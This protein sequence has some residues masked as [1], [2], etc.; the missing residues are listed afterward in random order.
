MPL[1]RQQRRAAARA[2]TSRHPLGSRLVMAGI[3]LG[4]AGLLA[5]AAWDRWGRTPLVRDGAPSWS[6]DGKQI[7]FY[8]E[9][10]GR[11]ADLFVM[12]ADGS[13]GRRLTDAPAMAEGYPAWSPD[14]RRIA[15]EGDSPNGNFDIYVMN[16]D[17]SNVQRLTSDPRR[18]VGPAWSPDGTRLVFMS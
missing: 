6:P 16:A 2:G 14:G 1:S 13:G 4:V 9:R 17:G 15:F 12:R 18:D 7:V 8:R 10:D 5:W 3:A 11:T